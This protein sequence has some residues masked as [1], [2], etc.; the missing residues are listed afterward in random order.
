M[1]NTKLLE[2]VFEAR[3][4]AKPLIEIDEIARWWIPLDMTHIVNQSLGMRLHP[5]IGKFMDL[6]IWQADAVGAPTKDTPVMWIESTSKSW[7]VTI[8]N[9]YR[10]EVVNAMPIL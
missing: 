9:D 1:A 6:P 3:I 4:K 7:R 10:V 2:A 5:G 8:L